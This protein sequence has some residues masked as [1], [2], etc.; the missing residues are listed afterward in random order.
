MLRHFNILHSALRPEYMDQCKLTVQRDDEQQTWSYRMEVAGKTLVSASDLPM[1]SGHN[2]AAFE[3][4]AMLAQLGSYLQK[5]FDADC[6]D[7]REVLRER[8]SEINADRTHLS[9]SDAALA[10]LEKFR[11]VVDS[12]ELLGAPG[13]GCFPGVE[14]SDD[15][16]SAELLIGNQSLG[17]CAI[18][19]RQVLTDTLR[20]MAHVCSSSVNHMLHARDVDAAVIATVQ[21]M[22][23]DRNER[24]VM[25]SNVH[26][27]FFCRTN[28][29]SAQVFEDD[30]AKFA[31]M[32][33]DSAGVEKTLVFSNR[34]PT[35][36]ELRGT[37][38]QE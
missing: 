29:A 1:Q 23:D 34:L 9:G 19:G 7:Q 16:A 17:S 8:F 3:D 24:K 18:L 15:L 13:K 2:L 35:N 30:P 21:D 5:A 10:M 6:V 28:F 20:T 36:S 27:P 12:L 37:N 26:D 38:L 11:M 22:V 14:L 31:A 32:F 4:H 33:R 25:E